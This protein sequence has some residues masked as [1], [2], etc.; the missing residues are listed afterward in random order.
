MTQNSVEQYNTNSSKVLK[1]RKYFHLNE[2][3]WCVITLHSALWVLVFY[4]SVLYFL[5]FLPSLSL[6]GKGG[7]K[8]LHGTV[9]GI[10]KRVGHNQKKI[11]IIKHA[12]CLFENLKV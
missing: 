9:H 1:S 10:T 8:R 3:V 2:C 11:L 12:Y 7:K 4:I 5:F 6:R